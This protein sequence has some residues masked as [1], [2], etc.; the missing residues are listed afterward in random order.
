[1][2][3][4]DLDVNCRA[5]LSMIPSVSN[6]NRYETIFGMAYNHDT[7]QNVLTTLVNQERLI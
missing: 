3:Y 5:F 6:F 4:R 2:A 7:H 1:M